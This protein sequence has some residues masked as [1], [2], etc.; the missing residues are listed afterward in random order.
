LRLNDG[1]CVC[2]GEHPAIFIRDNKPKH[3]SFFDPPRGVVAEFLL[4]LFDALFLAQ[5]RF[6]IQL[7]CR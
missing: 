7:K 1:I 3:L 6:Q 4:D 5:Q 2:L